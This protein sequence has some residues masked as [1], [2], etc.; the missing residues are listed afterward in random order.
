MLGVPVL[1]L[2]TYLYYYGLGP[3]PTVCTHSVSCYTLYQ[4][5]P[6]RTSDGEPEW[7]RGGEPSASSLRSTVGGSLV[8]LSCRTKCFCKIPFSQLEHR[9]VRELSKPRPG[10][11]FACVRTL[12]LISWVANWTPWRVRQTNP[13]VN[14]AVVAGLEGLGICTLR[15]TQPY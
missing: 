11:A 9:A 14:L 10:Q 15:W 1:Y 4:Q 6:G 2:Y 8:F 3:F 7:K 5:T 12:C 13:V